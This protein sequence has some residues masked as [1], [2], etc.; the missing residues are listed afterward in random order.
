VTVTFSGLIP[1]GYAPPVQAA[2]YLTALVIFGLLASSTALAYAPVDS[3]RR[4][5]A[6]LAALALL[7]AMALSSFGTLSS[8]GIPFPY[9][10]EAQIL[11]YSLALTVFA[12]AVAAVVWAA[13]ENRGQRLLSGLGASLVGF[14]MLLGRRLLGDPGPVLTDTVSL[15]TF[16]C[17]LGAVWL[18]YRADDARLPIVGSLAGR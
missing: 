15:L 9:T 14:Q 11:H 16:A 3:R 8:F 17:L 2:H 12:L 10:P 13:A 1:G 18:A 6:S 4:R 5:Q 7:P